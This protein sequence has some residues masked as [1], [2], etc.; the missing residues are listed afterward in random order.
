MKRSRVLKHEAECS[1]NP[2]RLSPPKQ[3]RPPKQLQPAKPLQ[4]P[5]KKPNKQQLQL[6]NQQQSKR[7][8]QPQREEAMEEEEQRF[9]CSECPGE[10]RARKTITNH[11]RIKKCE[12]IPVACTGT[13]DCCPSKGKWPDFLY[14]GPDFLKRA[15]FLIQ[16][17]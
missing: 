4:L 2:E 3:G 7:K 13:A 14:R 5:S 9:H 11:A 16:H 12:G 17:I 6:P 15:R 10:S 8:Q 1:W